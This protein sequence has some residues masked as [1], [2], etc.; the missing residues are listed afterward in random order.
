[1]IRTVAPRAVSPAAWQSFARGVASAAAAFSL[2]PK[3]Q[4]DP[5]LVQAGADSNDIMYIYM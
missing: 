1:V 4:K 2:Q 5:T 3:N